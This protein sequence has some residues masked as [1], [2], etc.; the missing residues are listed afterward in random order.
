MSKVYKDVYL[1]SDSDT[2]SESD[3]EY[4]DDYVGVT[5]IKLNNVN[6]WKASCCINF[7]PI[8]S[9]KTNKWKVEPITI[10]T[11]YSLSRRR[12]EKIFN[13]FN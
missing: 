2:E 12:I 7:S 4:Y 11:M 6:I 8:S 1:T 5:P 3:E 9:S 10:P 13:T